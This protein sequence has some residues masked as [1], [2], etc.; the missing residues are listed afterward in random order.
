MH[1]ERYFPYATQIVAPPIPF[2]ID[3]RTTQNATSPSETPSRVA[4]SPDIIHI[5]NETPAIYSTLFVASNPVI[6][7]AAN[8][9]RLKVM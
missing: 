2:I 1:S 8:A 4:M 7:G 5:V 3:P 9:D 6:D